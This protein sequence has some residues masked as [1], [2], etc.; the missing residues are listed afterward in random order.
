MVFG[1]T[2]LSIFWHRI[3][4]LRLT[5][6]PPETKDQVSINPQTQSP[7]SHTNQQY[8]GMIC[9][10]TDTKNIVSALKSTGKTET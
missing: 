10:H 4:A 8:F 1:H 6:T 9:V 3:E 2:K 5:H 7:H